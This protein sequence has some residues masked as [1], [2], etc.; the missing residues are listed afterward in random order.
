MLDMKTSTALKGYRE[1][2]GIVQFD[3]AVAAGIR[4]NT[5]ARVES[6]KNVSYTTAQNILKALNTFRANQ[7]LPPIGH[8]DILGLSIV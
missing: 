8:V 6:G 4:P 3:M 2:L 7:Q 5:Y 1:E